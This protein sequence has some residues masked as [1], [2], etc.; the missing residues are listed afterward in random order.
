MLEFIIYLALS[1]LVGKLAQKRG[2]RL[3]MWIFLSVLLS[4]LLL[5]IILFCRENLA[6]V[7]RVRKNTEA[8]EKQERREREERMKAQLLEIEER[9]KKEE[10]NLKPLNERKRYRYLV[11]K[12]EVGTLTQEEFVELEEMEIQSEEGVTA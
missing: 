11:Y 2:R 4:P 6:E 3:G 1:F 12:K 9:E 5:G 8:R 7:E 10:E